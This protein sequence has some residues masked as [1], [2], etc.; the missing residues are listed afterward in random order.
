MAIPSSARI[1]FCLVSKALRHDRTLRCTG[2]M[3]SVF[4]DPYNDEFAFNAR[5]GLKLGNLERQ[6]GDVSV[7]GPLAAEIWQKVCHCKQNC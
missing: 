7:D 5:P 6:S 4:N 1:Y 3:D 2:D